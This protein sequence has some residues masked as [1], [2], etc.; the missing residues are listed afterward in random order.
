MDRCYFCF[1]DEGHLVRPCHNELCSARAHCDCLAQQYQSNKNCGGCQSAIVVTS[2]INIGKIFAQFIPTMVYLFSIT[3]MIISLRMNNYLLASMIIF[4]RCY[5]H[6]TKIM[7]DIA[8]IMAVHQVETVIAN[9]SINLQ[10]P[11]L[12]ALIILLP[13]SRCKGHLLCWFNLSYLITITALFQYY[14]FDTVLV[15]ITCTIM[16]IIYH[17]NNKDHDLWLG[18][19]YAIVLFNFLNMMALYFQLNPLYY[20]TI[21]AGCHLFV[22]AAMKKFS[23]AFDY[24]YG[25]N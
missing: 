20:I 22:S 4:H 13:L 21:P 18:L 24:Q 17:Q 2:E 10:I 19:C 23:F 3:N 15:F 6:D 7:P 9:Y 5:Q 14:N 8:A 12:T 16:R 11:A 1:S 25:K